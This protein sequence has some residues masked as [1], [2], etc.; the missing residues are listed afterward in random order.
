MSNSYI[1]V[2]TEN[3]IKLKEICEE[4]GIEISM[5]SDPIQ[6][7]SQ[8]LYDCF[9]H[10]DKDLKQLFKRVETEDPIFVD[11]IEDRIGELINDTIDE[12]IE[13]IRDDIFNYINQRLE[14]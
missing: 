4:Q 2:S 6:Y 7:V 9:N 5:T 8:E 10:N 1:K 11:Y 13:Y 14:K 3:G 12:N